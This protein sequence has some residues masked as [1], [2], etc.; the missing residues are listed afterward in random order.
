MHPGREV[1]L[2]WTGTLRRTRTQADAEA[3]LR[4]WLALPEPPIILEDD[5]A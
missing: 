4:Q 3:R 5:P 1:G 2:G